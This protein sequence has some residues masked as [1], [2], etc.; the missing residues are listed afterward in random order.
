MIQLE[1]DDNEPIIR[2]NIINNNGLITKSNKKN[3]ID[4]MDKIETIQRNYKLRC[5]AKKINE[6]EDEYKIQRII[7]NNCEAIKEYG[8]DLNDNVILIQRNWKNYLNK[9][10]YDKNKDIISKCQI[11]KNN[12]YITK[13]IILKETEPLIINKDDI[14]LNNGN[15]IHFISKEIKKDQLPNIIYLQNKIKSLQNKKVENPI[16]TTIKDNKCSYVTKVKLKSKPITHNKYDDLTIDSNIPTI[17]YLEEIKPIKKINLS[18][19][20]SN[21]GYVTKERHDDFNGKTI[22]IQ[23]NVRKFINDKNKDNDD[24][25]TV[26][27]IKK[28]CYVN[29][30]RNIDNTKDITNIQKNY[31]DYLLRKSK[32]KTDDEL[33]K[34]I[35]KKPIKDICYLEKDITLL[36]K[37][38]DKIELIQDRFRTIRNKKDNDNNKNKPL[39]IILSND[40]SNCYITKD[41]LDNNDYLNKIQKI[42]N[43]YRNRKPNK[44]DN[45][46]DNIKFIPSS[47]KFGNSYLSKEN[48][49]YNI[50]D[51]EMNKIKNLQNE[52]RKYKNINKEKEN[53]KI[54]EPILKKPLFNE[55]ESDKDKYYITKEYKFNNNKE[56]EKIQRTYKNHLNN[57][58]NKNLL[59]IKKNPSTN[60]FLSKDNLIN[61]EYKLIPLQRKLRSINKNKDNLNN[62]Q[63]IK[64]PYEIINTNEYISK[65]RKTNDTEKIKPIQRTYRKIKYKKETKQEVKKD[66]IQ[67]TKKL[68]FKNLDSYI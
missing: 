4:D 13:S 55:D 3:L 44:N 68:Q 45:E 59:I 32:K 61:N 5:R 50:N 26:I 63:A 28:N 52:F 39:K 43:Y 9:K 49:I 51:D 48:K 22:N 6:E 11:P 25:V 46:L 7:P 60:L 67:P 2:K 66:I 62:I 30:T 12:S 36:R 33:N 34:N 14:N 64:K 1:K 35:I 8:I 29:K 31:K 42:Q 47:N 21:Q 15:N 53:V 40:M 65:E 57:L 17:E 41:R 23:R 16:K 56:I 20:E 10:S 24:F 19:Y 37:D 54:K 38:L 27:P 18:N 58:K